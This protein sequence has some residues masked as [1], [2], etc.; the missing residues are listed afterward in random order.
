MP[1][2]I[3]SF[4]IVYVFNDGTCS[5]VYHIPGTNGRDD[6]S[7]K[8]K[9]TWKAN[10]DLY[11]GRGEFRPMNTEKPD[12]SFGTT[13]INTLESMIYYSNQPCYTN[14]KDDYWGFDALG[15][16]L[17][18]EKIRHH[19]FSR[20][21]EM[22]NNRFD[23]LYNVDYARIDGGIDKCLEADM[24]KGYVLLIKAKKDGRNGAGNKKINRK[25]KR[26]FNEFT[27]D[28]YYYIPGVKDPSDPSKDMIF[29]HTEVIQISDWE[30]ASADRTFVYENKIGWYK[31]RLGNLPAKPI[32]IGV[33]EE[34][35]MFLRASGEEGDKYGWACTFGWQKV[36]YARCK[37][38]GCGNAN[39]TDDEFEWRNFSFARPEM[40]NGQGCRNVNGGS[41]ACFLTKKHFCAYPFE[42]GSNLQNF[43]NPD[44]FKNLTETNYE[45]YDFY[46]D[47]T[48][49][50]STCPTS[51]GDPSVRRLKGSRP[52]SFL[53]PITLPDKKVYVKINGWWTSQ[54]TIISP[55]PNIEEETFCASVVN[56]S[57]S[58][59]KDDIF[60]IVEDSDFNPVCSNKRYKIKIKGAFFDNI[61]K[62]SDED[63]NYNEIIGYYIVRNPRD[64]DNNIS[65][66]MK[67]L[68]YLPLETKK[69]SY[70]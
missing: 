60:R 32:I 37:T 53:S 7:G 63:V 29:L 30:Q 9:T 61:E 18:G 54:T 5:P 44:T 22:Y 31:I 3:Y 65:S 12:T 41:N 64:E 35:R 39:A 10:K 47:S 33:S 56:T 48:F 59:N 42:D 58:N 14:P 24:D 6:S 1:G 43:F 66:N 4:G 26:F 21:F 13:Y 20:R 45:N 28:I 70:M 36:K 57:T 51:V 2:E 69:V 62:P 25:Y 46:P 67:L 8:L 23:E 38:E 34:P 17:A 15:Q 40:A 11:P 27:I 68:L 16:P 50:D 55:N 19:R 52:Q 49:T